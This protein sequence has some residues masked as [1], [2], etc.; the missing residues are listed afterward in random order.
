VCVY[1]C[2]CVWDQVRAHAR[3]YECAYRTDA[4]TPAIHSICNDHALH[5][6]ERVILE[7]LL[8]STAR[9]TLEVLAEKFELTPL[10][11]EEG[12]PT[13]CALVFMWCVGIGFGLIFRF[14]HLS[15]CLDLT[16]VCV[17]MRVYSYTVTL[18]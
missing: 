8:A 7:K 12:E 5:A 3:I 2:V 14:L 16:C 6:L 13:L 4:Y 18:R 9:A 15:P 10:R 17:C 11:N 1:V